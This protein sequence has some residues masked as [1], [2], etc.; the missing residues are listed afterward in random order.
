MRIHKDLEMDLC[1]LFTPALLFPSSTLSL[2]LSLSLALFS[3]ARANVHIF[4]AT[5]LYYEAD[6]QVLVLAQYSYVSLTNC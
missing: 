3:D 5:K 4:L 1:L 6:I 2:S